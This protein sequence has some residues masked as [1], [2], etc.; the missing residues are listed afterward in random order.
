MAI[1]GY[2]SWVGNPGQLAYTGPTPLAGDPLAPFSRVRSEV[3][4]ANGGELNFQ[5]VNHKWFRQGAGLQVDAILISFMVIDGFASELPDYEISPDSGQQGI[6]LLDNAGNPI[7]P[8]TPPTYI[9][10]T[11]GLSGLAR[12]WQQMLW[13]MDQRYTVGGIELQWATGGR[14]AFGFVQG[15]TAW[16][17]PQDINF[18]WS[19]TNSDRALTEESDGGQEYT[20]QRGASRRT[21]RFNLSEQTV[22]E[23]IKP[24]TEGLISVQDHLGTS[25]PALIVPRESGDIAEDAFVF[26]RIPRWPSLDHQDADIYRMD[27]I[28]VRE[29]L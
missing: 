11:Q 2:K 9:G 27:A 13:I 21:L 25:N 1:I 14:I 23:S 19:I 6:W 10:P 7:D 22:S 15:I 5:D 24:A 16:R 28:E 8:P 4:V 18:D 3:M 12:R 20:Q 26:G 17:F 29:L